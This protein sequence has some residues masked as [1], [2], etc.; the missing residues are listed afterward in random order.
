M[1]WIFTLGGFSFW[2][3]M[4]YKSTVVNDLQKAYFCAKYVKVN[5]LRICIQSLKKCWN[6]RKV[7]NMS[8]EK[9]KFNDGFKFVDLLL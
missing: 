4:K 9:A 6:D 2:N 5:F 7:K 8:K 3:L 1:Y